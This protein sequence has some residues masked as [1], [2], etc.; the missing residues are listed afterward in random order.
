[1]AKQT[2][3]RELEQAKGKAKTAVKAAAADKGSLLF[4]TNATRNAA[5]GMG[6]AAAVR[7][8]KPK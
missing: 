8:A 1:M 7:R 4:P 6:T 2:R 3:D 5:R